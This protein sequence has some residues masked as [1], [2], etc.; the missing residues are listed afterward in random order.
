MPD[1]MSDIDEVTT[2][3]TVNVVFV[4]ARITNQTAKNN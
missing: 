4:V 2:K 3:I 1:C